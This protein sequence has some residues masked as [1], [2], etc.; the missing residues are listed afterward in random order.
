MEAA[1]EPKRQLQ[2]AREKSAEGI[3]L[4][5]V[6]FKLGHVFPGCDKATHPQSLIK[7]TGTPLTFHTL[8]QPG[9]SCT[10]SETY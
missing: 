2:E 3:F 9:M 5:L 7:M 10:A 1:D 4:I 6:I 8:T